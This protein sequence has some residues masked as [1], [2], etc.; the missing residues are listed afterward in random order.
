MRRFVNTDLRRQTMIFTFIGQDI[1][2]LLPS[3]L[4]DLLYQGREAADI[5]VEERNPAMQDVLER[6]GNAVLRHAG[7]GGSLTV[8]GERR[9]LLWNADC[10]VYAGDCMASSR[11]RQDR[12]A[13]CGP[14]D[15]PD[16]P[17]L[18]DQARV[19]GGIGGLMHTLR[20]G[21]MVMELA[22]E[23]QT[24]CP[25][26]LVI[27]L[28]QPVART[29]EIFRRMGFRA[30]GLGRSPLR[31]PNGLDALCAKLH[32]KVE[33]VSADIAGLPD[34]AWLLRLDDTKAQDDLMPIINDLAEDED[35]LGRLSSRWL[36]LF[37]AL[38]VG[39]VTRHAEW[40]AAQDDYA[41]NPE[42]E[43]GESVE[44]R[45]ERILYMNTVGDKGL[46]PAVPR[47]QPGE[48]VMAQ[49]LLLSK[50][51]AIRPVQLAL[52]LLRRES[53]TIPAVTRPNTLG[54]IANLPRVAIIEAPLTLRAGEEQPHHFIL[55]AA[56]ADFC[57]D[58]DET[59]RLAA[60][61]A[62]GDR[63]AL[64]ECIELDPALE[65]LD[66]LYCQQLVDALIALHADVITRL[67]GD[68][69]EDE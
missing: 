45:K 67:G 19:N 42:P 53:V 22:E 7:I 14:E 38:P 56:L 35:G 50:A 68:D 41:P 34:F 47:A 63:T 20:Q 69:E 10:V 15:D 64:R 12:Q 13:L 65:G 2:M 40:M 21:E 60:R 1:P 39:D 66:R 5:R 49:L 29:T 25:D 46:E 55:P 8:S 9:A 54:E 43:L 16:D 31:G 33:D 6:Y 23:M 28:G 59:S 26:A 44:K 58:V 4:A 27:T 18:T 48:G 30:Y 51:P 37:G 3:L 17:G 62:M 11:F 61:A 52:A 36:R 32:A 24:V 57:M